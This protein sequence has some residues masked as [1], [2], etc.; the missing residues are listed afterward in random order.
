MSS[1]ILPY[2]K[3]IDEPSIMQSIR[4]L[5]LITN[6]ADISNLYERTGG[7]PMRSKN[8]SVDLTPKKQKKSVGRKT[9]N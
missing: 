9:P 7:S 4:P 5:T 6:H 2:S 8:K 1:H 3:I